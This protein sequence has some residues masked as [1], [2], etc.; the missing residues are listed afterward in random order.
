MVGDLQ[1]TSFAEVWRESNSEERVRLVAEI[2]ALEPDFLVAVGD[3]VFC[4]SSRVDWG[5]FD[6]L[7]APLRN[8]RVPLL[9]ILGNHE[10][11]MR[12]APALRNYFAR[13][14]YL[15]G[16]RWYARTYGPLGLVF[17]DSNEVPLGAA[18]WTEQEAWLGETLATLDSA[19][20]VRG[21]LV[22][23]HHPPYTNST[24]T[25]DE[26]HV[27]RTFVPPFLAARKTLA[28]VSGHVHSYER[29]VEGGKTFLVTGGGGGPRVKLARGARRRHPEDLFDG[30]DVRHFHFLLGIPSK[31][32][33]D[34]EVRGLEKR[35]EA[36]RTLD[37]FT[38][39]WP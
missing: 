38:L 21:V 1:R 33:L 31:S 25:P 6:V 5:E 22:F 10:Y 3:L 19:A 17:L 26:A 34:I 11:W 36:F 20:A 2:A 24:V 39:P 16:R 7:A 9:P 35:G 13:F 32:A 4:G 18:R 30:P 37:R 28:M 12:K 15:E 29:F 27:Q 8:A 23:A 14:P